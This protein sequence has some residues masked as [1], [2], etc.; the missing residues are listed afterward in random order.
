MVRLSG[1][2]EEDVVEVGQMNGEAGDL[3][4]GEIELVEQSRSERTPAAQGI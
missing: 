3:D 4:R 1:E 2:R